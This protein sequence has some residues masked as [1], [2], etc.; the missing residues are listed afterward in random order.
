MTTED[1][2]AF[3]IFD[4]KGKFVGLLTS[5]DLLKVVFEGTLTR[6]NRVKLSLRYATSSKPDSSHRR[7]GLDRRDARHGGCHVRR[8]FCKA[9]APIP[10]GAFVG[11]EW[12]WVADSITTLENGAR[13]L[14]VA[15][16]TTKI[17]A[18]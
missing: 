13:V 8:R 3:P 12:R 18:G 6:S 5:L 4:E 2:R 16:G 10:G 14:V 11:G 15:G 17:H 7:F 1:L 9:F